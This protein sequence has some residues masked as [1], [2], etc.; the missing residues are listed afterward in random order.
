MFF[1][2]VVRSALCGAFVLTFN[3]QVA[4]Q[5]LNLARNENAIAQSVAASLLVDVYK[6]A[7]L[8]AKIQPLPGARANAMTLAGEKDGEVARIQAYATKNP[9]LIKVE[10][11]YYYLT[12]GAFAKADKGVSV[13]SKDDLKKYKVG[14]VRGIAHAE[15]AT[16]G[17]AGLQVAGTYDQLYQMLDAGRIDVAIDEGINGPGAVKKLGLKD[18]K[19]VGEIAKL[20][21]FNMLH[22]SKKD[23]APKISA[24][25]KALKDSGELAKLTR[26]YEETALAQ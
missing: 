5:E 18:I 9:T 1:K 14:I 6:K 8:T 16:E 7:G 17:L 26:K 25:I 23:L 10:P 11:G 3:S 20:D 21:L 12:T 4:A 13:N 22:P 15:A 2:T 24:A 19:Q